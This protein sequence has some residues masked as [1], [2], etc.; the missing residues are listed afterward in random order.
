MLKFLIRPRQGGYGRSKRYSDPTIFH[1]EQE[2]L[3]FVSSPEIQETYRSLPLAGWYKDRHRSEPT[4]PE[5]RKLVVG[6]WNPGYRR[7]AD[8]YVERGC[9]SWGVSVPLFVGL[10]EDMFITNLRMYTDDLD[11]RIQRKSDDSAAQ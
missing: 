7:T 1:S 6:V 4:N 5:E 10:A 8:V 2:L 11:D 3:D 9:R